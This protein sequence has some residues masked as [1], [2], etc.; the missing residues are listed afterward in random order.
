VNLDTP[1]KRDTVTIV[2]RDNNKI[3]GG[4]FTKGVVSMHTTV[5]TLYHHCNTTSAPL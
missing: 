3:V 5:T 1:I 2:P 4:T